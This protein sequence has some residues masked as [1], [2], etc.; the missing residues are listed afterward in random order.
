MPRITQRTSF[1]RL[2]RGSVVG[3]TRRARLCVGASSASGC[4]RLVASHRVACSLVKVRGLPRRSLRGVLTTVPLAAAEATRVGFLLVGSASRRVPI[5]CDADASMVRGN[6]PPCLP[7]SSHAGIGGCRGGGGG[8]ARGGGGSGGSP[9]ER[10]VNVAS[11]VLPL[12]IL[13]CLSLDSRDLAR[14]VS[15][16]AA[17][18]DAAIDGA[19]RPC[20]AHVSATT[21][22]AG[23]HSLRRRSPCHHLF[24][25]F[26]NCDSTTGSPS[27]PVM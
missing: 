18:T 4:E 19:V 23:E 13:C 21:V 20:N 7:P 6:P 26:C 9:A 15:T 10:A 2:M 27:S 11:R 14:A 8:T 5:G 24:L 25:A 16:A 17:A 12:R 3:L 1:Q 22:A